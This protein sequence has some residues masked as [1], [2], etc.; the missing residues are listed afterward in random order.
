[1]P[2][3]NVVMG[4]PLFAPLLFGTSAYL[5]VIVS[6]L[7]REEDLD[8]FG[9][10]RSQVVE[11]TTRFRKQDFR[12]DIRTGRFQR[13][14]CGVAALWNALLGNGELVL[15]LQGQLQIPRTVVADPADAA[16]ACGDPRG[17]EEHAHRQYAAAAGLGGADARWCRRFRL[18][19]SR[20]PRTFRW[21]EKAALQHSLRASGLRAAAVCGVRLLGMMA[22]L[23]R[24]ER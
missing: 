13:H 23:M 22:Y 18:S 12:N 24:R 3:T 1:M 21:R 20:H 2:V 19:P 11:L 14:L 5:G 7:Q 16:N 9:G 17:P 10:A 4:P 6:Y 15:A 8:G